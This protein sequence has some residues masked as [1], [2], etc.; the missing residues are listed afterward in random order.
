MVLFNQMLQTAL[1]LS[2]E[3]RA[4]ELWPN[5]STESIA[6]FGLRMSSQ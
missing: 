4:R 6:V 2:Q 5:I 3:K 1:Q